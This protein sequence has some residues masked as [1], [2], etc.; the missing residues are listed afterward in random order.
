[1]F[2]SVFQRDEHLDLSGRKVTVARIISRVAPAPLI[3]LYVGLILAIWS[4]IGLGPHFTP[5]TLMIICIAMMVVLPI[6]PI[7]AQAWR[8]TVDLDVSERTSRPKFFLWSLLCYAIAYAI[9]ALADSLIMSAL[10]A[11]YF[12]VTTGVMLASLKTKVSVHVAGIA[13]PGTALILV[14][15]LP[16]LAIIVAW[17]LVAWSRTVLQQHTLFQTLL[18]ILL[19]AAITIGTYLVFYFPLL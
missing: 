7:V 1:M 16:A 17:V 10:A 15:G 5:I 19:G 6:A 13:G 11:A 4:P 3:N 9:Y 18:G 14:F 2:I 12:F 8:G